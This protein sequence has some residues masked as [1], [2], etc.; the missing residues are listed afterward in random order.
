MWTGFALAVPIGIASGVWTAR[1]ELPGWLAAI[2]GGAL[3]LVG[4]LV[5]RHFGFP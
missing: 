2:F 4:A 5:C 3:A 1:M